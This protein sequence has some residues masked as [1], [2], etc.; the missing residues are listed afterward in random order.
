[1]EC[2]T[3]IDFFLYKNVFAGR[4]PDLIFDSLYPAEENISKQLMWDNLHN[5]N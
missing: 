1:M 3:T 5:K 4:F 2:V